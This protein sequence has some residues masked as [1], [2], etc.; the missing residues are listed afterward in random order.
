MLVRFVILCFFFLAGPAFCQELSA[1]DAQLLLGRLLGSDSELLEKL[2][3]E[4]RSRISSSVT[5]RAAVVER[6]QRALSARNITDSIQL[7]RL[8]QRLYPESDEFYRQF[9][10]LTLFGERLEHYLASE[11]IEALQALLGGSDLSR[12]ERSIAEAQF[13]G[14]VHSRGAELVR[15]GRGQEALRLLAALPSQLYTS[16]TWTL[17]SQLITGIAANPGQIAFDYLLQGKTHELLL[18]FSEVDPGG[19]EIFLKLLFLGFLDAGRRGDAQTSRTTLAVLEELNAPLD[20]VLEQFL[21]QSRGAAKAEVS[22]L[23]FER[24]KSQGKIS[25]GTKWQLVLAG[26]YGP[27]I[28]TLIFLSIAFPLA[29]VF[30]LIRLKLRKKGVGELKVPRSIKRKKE[31]P[32]YLRPV[33]VK[34]EQEPDDEYSRLLRMFALSDSAGE[35]EIKQ[36]YRRKMKELHPDAAKV[37]VDMENSEAFRELKHAYDRIMEIRSSWFRGRTGR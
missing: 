12:V 37:S 35:S 15:A 26:Y 34:T 22:P 31:L 14:Y 32:G 36:A 6:Y 28:P 10:K 9:E 24:L 30:L 20:E 19:R 11:N 16:E 25:L 27:V 18:K 29:A 2:P 33:E 7:K 23:I 1:Q 5:F 4:K 21:F 13:G 8:V 17:C 3:D